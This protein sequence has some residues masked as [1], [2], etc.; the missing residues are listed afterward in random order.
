MAEQTDTIDIPTPE[1]HEGTADSIDAA[2]DGIDF[3]DDVE[4]DEVEQVEDDA[5]EPEGVE[6]TGDE[7]EEDAGDEPD[8]PGISR[9]DLTRAMGILRRDNVPDELIQDWIEN[10]PEKLIAWAERSGKRQGDIDRRL[11]VAKPDEEAKE[12][13][14]SDKAEPT[15][16]PAD[17]KSLAELVRPFA[18]EMGSEHAEATLTSLAKHVRDST[19]AEVR[20]KLEAF[21]QG[22]GRLAQTL[23]RMAVKQAR[24][25]LRERFPQVSDESKWAKV[26]G[27][28]QTLSKTGGYEDIESVLADSARLEFGEFKLRD[29]Q[30]RLAK[31]RHTRSTGTPTIPT[32][33]RQKPPATH[34]DKIDAALDAVLGPAD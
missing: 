23:E 19:L 18:D 32:R 21:E 20:P 8:A 25:G 33:T 9:D 17:D 30:A 29:E 11:G 14:E 15:G 22:Y 3:G 16:S 4:S 34:S 12:T 26:M 5:P 24:D 13:D 27:R 31:S 28:A 1:S 10:N 7:T 6:E 2:L